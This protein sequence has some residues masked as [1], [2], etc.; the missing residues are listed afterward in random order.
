[1]KIQL[2][3]LCDIIDLKNANLFMHNKNTNETVYI[4]YEDIKKIK[5]YIGLT[6][7]FYVK[8]IYEDCGICIEIKFVKGIWKALKK[9][10][11]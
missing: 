4:D 10:N 8:E 6:D 5:H 9:I 7:K 1:M 3:D 11:S 2:Q